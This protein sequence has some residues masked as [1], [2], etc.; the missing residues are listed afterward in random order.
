M[1]QLKIIGQNI[2]SLRKIKKISQEELSEKM[3]MDRSYFSALENG[4]VNFKANTLIKIAAA[5]GC[6]L[7]DLFVNVDPSDAVLED[8][9]Q[10]NK[11]S[12]L[13]GKDIG[14]KLNKMSDDDA[15]KTLAELLKNVE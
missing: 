7:G 10:D 3:S 8:T 6:K 14:A 11:S 4:K 2:K 5:L 1:D 15:A 12:S 13:S 9:S